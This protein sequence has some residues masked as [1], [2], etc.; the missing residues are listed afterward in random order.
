MVEN[1]EKFQQKYPKSVSIEGTQKILDQMKNCV[2]KIILENGQRGTGFFC[3]IPCNNKLI[4]VM[5]TNNHII[6]SH[7][8][9]NNKFILITLDN[10]KV[11]KTIKLNDKKIIYTNKEYD[12]TI[13]EVNPE[14]DE[15]NYYME[16]ED[17]IFKK[18]SYLYYNQE[19]VYIMDYP[20]GEKASVSYG[21]INKMNNTDIIHFSSIENGSSGCP[22]MSIS[23]NKIIGIHK[24]S[25]N[26]FQQNKGTFLK[27]PVNEFIHK[28]NSGK[29]DYF[30][31]SNILK[32]EDEINF[33]ISAL[34]KKMNFSKISKIYT[35]T[36][37]GDTSEDFKTY[38]N[39]KGPTL[40]ILKSEKDE[41]FGGFTKSNWNNEDFAYGYDNDAF[42]YS[43]TNKKVFDILKP[44]Q[45]IVNYK[46][47]YA[48]ACFGNKNDWDGIYLSDNFLRKAGCYCNPK[49]LTNIYNLKN[50]E[51][52]CS[53]DVCMLKEMEVYQIIS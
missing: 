44:E 49:K 17:K 4:P 3:N 18:E 31:D 47:G 12:V 21:L 15:I 1:I 46:K 16:L 7:Y 34:L 38:C 48:F 43:I 8:I 33:I 26:K 28:Y 36:I 39:N 51:D 40:I 42:M 19:S 14:E 9:N 5:I 22:I 25:S 32:K 41:I 52:L 2:F 24:E 53:Q 35:A 45:A 27:E 23:N 6:D 11:D 37:H 13:I 50:K 30:K 29:K 10:D 20:K